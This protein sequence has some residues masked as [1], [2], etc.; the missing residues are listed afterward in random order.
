MINPT[1]SEIG[2]I[3]KQL[4]ERINHDVKQKTTNNQWKNTQ[5]VIDWFK[6][7]RN[8]ETSGFICFDIVDFYPSISEDLLN[9]ALDF[10]STYTQISEENRNIIMHTKKALLYDNGIPWCK[11]S[12]SVF[13]VTMGSYDGAETCE[14]IGLYLLSQMKEID[15]NVGLYRDDGLAVCQKNPGK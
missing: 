12:H 13:D 5:E 9:K 1:E 15:I 6:K 14:L 11:K 7:I 3:S 2:K 4:L 8:K 10:A